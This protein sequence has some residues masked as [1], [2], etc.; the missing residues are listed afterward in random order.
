MAGEE[1]LR[2]KKG[3]V[4]FNRMPSRSEQLSSRRVLHVT[5]SLAFP[6]AEANDVAPL[7]GSHDLT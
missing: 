7:P 6:L 1:E 4:N 5:L 2:G 3:R